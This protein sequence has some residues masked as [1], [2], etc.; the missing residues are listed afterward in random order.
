MFDCIGIGRACLDILGIYHRFPKIDEKMKIKRIIIEGGGQTSTALVVLSRLGLKVK[1]IGRIGKD[2]AGKFVLE[3]MK[4]EGI[5]I[6]DVIW[7][8]E[9]PLAMIFVSR[10]GKRTIL[11]SSYE[12]LEPFEIDERIIRKTR[13]MLFDPQESETL[14]KNLDRIKSNGIKI[15][16]DAEKKVKGIERIIR[17]VDYF[18]ASSSF[19]KDYFGNMRVKDGIR[20]LIKMGGK[21]VCVTLGEKGSIT[22]YKGKWIH[23]PAFKVK[24]VDTTGC[25]DTYHAGFIYG[26]LKGW[27]EVRSMKFAS[28]LAGLCA[29]GLGGREAF[30]EDLNLI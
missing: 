13:I 25:G 1:F 2:L 17:E 15:V 16:Y 22:F 8:K 26:I 10:T 5:D 23:V 30:Y 28:Y 7:E 9:T 21:F 12:K 4:R 18:I 29:K 24:V 20:K 19:I 11:Y 3:K 6:N 14:L 27:D